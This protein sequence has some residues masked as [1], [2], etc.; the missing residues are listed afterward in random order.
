QKIVPVSHIT[1]NI[2]CFIIMVS[3]KE[4]ILAAKYWSTMKLVT[5]LQEE[6]DHLGVIINGQ[7]YSLEQLHR[8]LPN[9]MSMFLN[10]WD[11][12]LPLVPAAEWLIKEGNTDVIAPP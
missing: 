8:E 6:H 1:S 2:T 7:L 4:I 5:Y 3:S 12:Y 10:S 9:N 11:D